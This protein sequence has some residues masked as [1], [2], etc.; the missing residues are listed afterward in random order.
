MIMYFIV[1]SNIITS[2]S[3]RTGILSEE[4]SDLTEIN[5]LLTTQKLSVENS[6]AILNFVQSRN[7]IQATSVTHIF[8]SGDV[9]ALR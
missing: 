7:M 8:E 1:V 9:A 5:G 3:Y 4:L 6:S 2:S